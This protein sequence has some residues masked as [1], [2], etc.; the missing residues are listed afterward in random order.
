MLGINKG[1]E[2]RKL[3]IIKHI[4]LESTSLLNQEAAGSHTQGMASLPHQEDYQLPFPHVGNSPP[5]YMAVLPT[6]GGEQGKVSTCAEDAKMQRG[7]CFYEVYAMRG[8]MMIIE[9]CLTW[10]KD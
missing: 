9:A 5:P 6:G 2:A 7:R 4:Q 8:K 1:R 10:E 3:N